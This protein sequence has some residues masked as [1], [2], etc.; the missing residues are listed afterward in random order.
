MDNATEFVR[1]AFTVVCFGFFVLILYFI[2]KKGSKHHYS[3]AA[4]HVFMDDDTA[5]KAQDTITHSNGVNKNGCND[6]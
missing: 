4:D 2:F 6:N 1:I 5:G 3:S